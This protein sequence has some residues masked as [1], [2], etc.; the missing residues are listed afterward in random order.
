HFPSARADAELH[1]VRRVNISRDRLIELPWAGRVAV[2][3]V[4][5]SS[6]RAYFYAVAALRTIQPAAI[7]PDHSAR[8]TVSGLDGILSHP[9]AANACAAFAKNASLGIVCD[10]RRE[11]FFRSFIF[12]LAKAFLYIAP[13]KDHFLEFALAASVADR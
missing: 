1:S 2:H 7:G 6:G 12:F 11:I 3:T 10:D 5:Q 8:T 4:E 9:F 13:I